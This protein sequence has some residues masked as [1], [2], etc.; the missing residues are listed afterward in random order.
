MRLGLISASV[1]ALVSSGIAPAAAAWKDYTYPELS[2]GKEFPAEPAR[3][4][5]E[6]KTQVA[7]TAKAT[8]LA[9]KDDNI[10]YKVVVAE[11]QHKADVGA[12]IM[13]ECVANA[14]LE[15]EVLANMGTRIEPGAK[16]VHGRIVS[17]NLD[18]D[19]GR[20]QTACLFTQG[21]LYIIQATVLPEHG[22]PNSS[23]VIRFV[24][25]LRFDLETDW[26]KV[27][28]NLNEAAATQP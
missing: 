3:R 25:S 2:L 27:D 8:E 12:S 1:I 19:K 16:A 15:G 18:N 5:I 10:E 17:V 14:E 11:L 4:A 21:R 26:S 13:G 22:Q 7:G 9:A 20:R 24:N 23:Q 6:Y 28:R